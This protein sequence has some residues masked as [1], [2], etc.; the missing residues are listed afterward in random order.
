[1]NILPC[2]L[3]IRLLYAAPLILALSA[4]AGLT[5]PPLAPGQSEAD[6]VARLGRPSN[7]Y[8]EGGSRLLEYRRGPMGQ[9]TDM[10]RIGPDGRLKNVSRP[11]KA[12]PAPQK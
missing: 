5:G 7:V 6:V 11:A 3:P 4:C 1:M 9:T 10:A 2:I 12:S 8:P